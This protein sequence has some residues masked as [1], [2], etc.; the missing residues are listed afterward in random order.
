MR[1]VIDGHNDVLSHLH[2]EGA[3]DA[4]LL[5]EGS[6]S[7]TVPSAREGGLAAGLFAVLPPPGP[8]RDRA[9]ARRL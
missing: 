8:V 9:H 1:R 4:A 6:A 3:G 2:E 5:R 7:I